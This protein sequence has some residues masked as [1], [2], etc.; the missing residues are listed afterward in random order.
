MI[1]EPIQAILG[2]GIGGGKVPVIGNFIDHS[3]PAR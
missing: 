2:C 1:P 3:V